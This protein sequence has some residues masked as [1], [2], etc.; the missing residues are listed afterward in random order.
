M[1]IQWP[2]AGKLHSVSPGQNL[3]IEGVDTTGIVLGLFQK[4]ISAK[5]TA[6]LEREYESALAGGAV[7][8][9][10]AEKK[11]ALADIKAEVFRLQLKEAALL[12][13]YVE[14]NRGAAPDWIYSDMSPAALLGLSV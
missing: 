1:S 2:T 6:D 7:V 4:K 5:L 13:Q 11:K 14:A 3:Y 9:S 12:W 8:L 10:F